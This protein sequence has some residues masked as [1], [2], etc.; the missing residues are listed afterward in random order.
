MLRSS[1]LRNLAVNTTC[2]NRFDRTIACANT[3]SGTKQL[4]LIS[5]GVESSTLIHLV[6]NQYGES[7]GGLF[8]DYGQR[9]ARQEERAARLQCQ[10]LG[11]NM[12]ECDLT[13]VVPTFRTRK[14]NAHVPIPHRNLVILSV[15]T[16]IA[17]QEGFENVWIAVCKDDVSWYPSASNE[18]L[19]RFRSCAESLGIGLKLPLIDKCKAEVVQLGLQHGVNF[20]TTFSCMI[21]RG[22]V[23]CGRCVQC[24][25]RREA[26][27]AAG[28]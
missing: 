24:K 23:H 3:G 17:A 5:G 6:H 20:D 19:E 8:F 27:D 9:A 13:S 11:L 14:R 15:A 2:K 7:A 25:A 28:I 26:F 22:G 10:S 18:F 16:S 4:V 21:G 12:K 1:P